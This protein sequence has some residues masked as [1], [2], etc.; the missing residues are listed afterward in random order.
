MEIDKWVTKSELAARCG[1]STE[2]LRRE[3]KNVKG[4]RTGR[5]QFLKPYELKMF[6]DHYYGHRYDR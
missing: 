1:F 6:Y 5:R 2:Q 4:L 3:M